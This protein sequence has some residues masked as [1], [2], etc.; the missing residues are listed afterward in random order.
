MRDF[1]SIVRPNILRLSDAT[2][3]QVHT[4]DKMIKVR[5]DANENPFNAPHNRYHHNDNE[6]LKNMLG[7]MK[8]IWPHC[9]ALS[10]GTDEA[11]DFIFRVF[12]VPQQDNIL[13]ISPTSRRYE[14]YALVND[15]AYRPIYLNEQYQIAANHVLSLTDEHTKVIFLCSP[16]NPT[17]NLLNREE[18]LNICDK[19]HGVVVVD[20]GYN[21]FSRSESI[22]RCISQHHNLIVLNTLSK[23]FASA[24]LRL[25]IIYAVPEIIRYIKTIIPHHHISHW[26]ET[27]G[28]EI[29]K[30]RFEV[31]KWINQL[32]E[33]R[34][35]VMN[36]IKQLPF[37]KA[38]YP[39]DANFFLAK[40]KNATSVHQFLHN[41]G[42]A[43]FNC[44]DLP[45]C[46]NCLRITVGLPNENSTLIGALRK[47][48]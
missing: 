46:E 34:T 13:A 41:E 1:K 40:F 15:V 43:V 14:E 4:N 27:Q 44:S 12:C 8:G 18:L 33:E 35:K 24:D 3:T 47:Y 31:D 26:A 39:T 10:R 30:R 32:L 48:K 7:K 6:E 2:A 20:E 21:E 25:S 36:A 29:L 22:V 16:N 19:F 28:I 17:G 11:I 42:I 23:A 45:E 9:I 37:C 5:L 38:V